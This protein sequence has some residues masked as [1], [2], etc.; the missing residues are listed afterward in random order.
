MDPTKT[1]TLSPVVLAM[2]WLK[3]VLTREQKIGYGALN[4]GDDMV[5]SGLKNKI[6]VARSK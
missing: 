3:Y 4:Q 1:Y 6:N 5:I 2:N